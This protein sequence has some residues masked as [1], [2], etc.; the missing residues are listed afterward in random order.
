MASHL[1]ICMTLVTRLCKRTRVVQLAYIS[2]TEVCNKRASWTMSESCYHIFYLVITMIHHI[3]DTLKNMFFSPTI[4]HALT[5][6]ALLANIP[7]TD[8]LQDTHWQNIRGQ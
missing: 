8:N 6:T 7:R 3:L 5:I 2:L 4:H 1:H